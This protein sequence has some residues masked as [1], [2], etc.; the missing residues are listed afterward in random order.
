MKTRIS[1]DLFW[2]NNLFSDL[3]KHSEALSL[4]CS[5]IIYHLDDFSES[6]EVAF[7]DILVKKSL[8]LFTLSVHN[9]YPEAGK[10]DVLANIRLVLG[11]LLDDYSSFEVYLSSQIP[12]VSG[13]DV[14]YFNIKNADSSCCELN[15]QESLEFIRNELH[16]LKVRLL[17]ESKCKF[18]LA[19]SSR[20]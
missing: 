4:F 3:H 8:H 11:Q 19:L 18:T 16:K 12:D 2:Y 10:S 14:L 6:Y 17:P 1:T 20:T 7:K 5:L 9:L 13:E 15:D